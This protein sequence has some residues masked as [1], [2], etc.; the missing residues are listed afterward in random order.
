MT[1]SKTTSVTPHELKQARAQGRSRTD[2]AKLRA[3]TPFVWNGD[4]EDE[5]PP[6]R[7]ALTRPF[8]AARRRTGRTVDRDRPHPHLNPPPPPPRPPSPG[9]AP[10]PRAW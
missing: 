6:S 2:L 3:A 5:R 1:G 4:N 9:P 8:Q 7:P 10:A